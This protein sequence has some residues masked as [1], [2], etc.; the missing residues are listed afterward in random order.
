MYR[1]H[2]QAE[3]LQLTEYRF[4][5]LLLILAPPQYASYDLLTKKIHLGLN[6]QQWMFC[7]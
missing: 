1:A 4:L 2:K 3:Y 5:I 7:S 6:A